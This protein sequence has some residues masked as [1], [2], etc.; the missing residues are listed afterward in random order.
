MPLDQFA[1][2]VR[3]ADGLTEL[4]GAPSPFS[5]RKE[6]ASLDAHMRRF[7]ARSP[8][9]VV[10]THSAEGRCDASP[11]GDAPGFVR[12]VDD[13]TLLVPDRRG[14][15]RLDSLRNVVETGR[16]GL[17]F[18][19]PGAGETL[20]V[21]GRA[22]VIRDEQWLAGMAEGGKVPL[23]ALAVE[24]EECFLQCA[25]ALVR[26]RL[27]EPASWPAAAELPCAAEAFAEQVALPG[28]DAEAVRAMLD[29]AYRTGLY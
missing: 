18:L 4:V 6:K 7:V 2:H 11:R 3:T 15:R 8:F 27:W 28:M 1:H 12:V 19:V 21:N 20:R 22:A 17:L 25:K 5:L 14:N 23:L 29:E 13:R 9:L 24:A 26:S 10:S 16:A